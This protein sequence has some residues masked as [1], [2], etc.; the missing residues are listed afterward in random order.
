MA[1]LL[2][3]DLT[4]YRILSQQLSP[5][6][7]LA[8]VKEGQLLPEEWPVVLEKIVT[9]RKKFQYF[10]VTDGKTTLTCNSDMPDFCDRIAKVELG[11]I[12]HLLGSRTVFSTQNNGYVVIAED[13]ATLKQ[14]D[15]HLREIREAEARR[16]AD[17][18]DE[19]SL[20]HAASY[21]E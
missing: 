8:L 21:A 10:T 7:N 4:L 15:E 9:Y 1:C 17:L 6:P 16:L 20:Y 18:H 3:M 19:M 5:A 14:Y 12:I 11:T 13:F 2:R